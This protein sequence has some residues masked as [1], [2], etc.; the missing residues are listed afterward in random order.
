MLF[1]KKPKP[2]P[3]TRK[4]IE[5]S[6]FSMNMSSEWIDKSIYSIEGPEDDGIKHNIRVNIEDNVEVLDVATIARDEIMGLANALD[7]FQELYQG[8]VRLNG[9]LPAYEFLYKCMPV[10][11]RE[12]YQRMMFVLAKQSLFTLTV[13]F[14]EKTFKRFG[15]QVDSIYKSFTVM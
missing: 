12:V 3:S 8:P 10:E 5:D 2:Q 7:A 14:S 13:S 9:S 4:P 6:R 1:G 15:P 11:K